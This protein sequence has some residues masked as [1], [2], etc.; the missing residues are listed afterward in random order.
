MP[1]TLPVVPLSSPVTVPAVDER[2]FGI[3]W[4][5]KLMVDSPSPSQGSIYVEI[6]PMEATTG[7]LHPTVRQEITTQELWMAA[8]EVP[9]V[10][11]AIGAILMALPDLETWVAA[12]AAEQQQPPE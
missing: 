10:A 5:R 6:A 2:V 9:S 3:T 4:L 11:N 1:I 12:R 8:Q 7:E